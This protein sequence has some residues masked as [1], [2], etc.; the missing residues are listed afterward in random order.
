VIVALG[1]LVAPATAAQQIIVSAAASLTNAF[2][3]IG[4]AFESANPGVTV[5][6]NFAASDILATQIQK[7][8]RPDV[9][10]SADEEAMNRGLKAGVIVAATRRD[11]AANALVL[12][13]APGT[14][15][16][17]M[18]TDLTDA[19]FRRIALGSPQTV[20]A[21]RYAKAALE[22]A[23]LWTK[24]EPRFVFAQNVRQVL[25][26][27]ARAEADAG[28]VYATDAATTPGKVRVAFDVATPTSVRYPIAVVKDSR[29][30]KIAQAFVAYVASDAGQN[31]LKRYGFRAP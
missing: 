31:I 9:F 2:R 24:L 14:K 17:T 25:D 3:D 30:E 1:V 27:V 12:V 19:R 7:G 28:F 16:P 20:P 8:A 29:N 18:L 23:K 21:G 22:A 15:T 4:S 11:F 13:V 26:Y 5:A 6:F 10:A